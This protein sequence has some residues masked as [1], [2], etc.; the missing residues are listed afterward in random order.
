MKLYDGEKIVSIEMYEREGDWMPPEWSKDFFDAGR[1]EYDEDLDA[2]M[3]QDVDY[4]VEQANDWKECIGDFN[5]DEIPDG[6]E[7]LVYVE[8]ISE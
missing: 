8:T 6:W 3:V 2:Y 1:L 5:C 4:C 7:R